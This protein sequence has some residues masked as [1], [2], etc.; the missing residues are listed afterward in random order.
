MYIETL[1][2][3]IQLYTEKTMAT[4]IKKGIY[5]HLKS[6]TYYKVVGTALLERNP[7]QTMVLYKQLHK[8]LLRNPYDSRLPDTILKSGTMWTRPIEE[9]RASFQLCTANHKTNE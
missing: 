6:S 2:N 3:I 9:F 7:T 4:K 1:Y 8:S 5:R